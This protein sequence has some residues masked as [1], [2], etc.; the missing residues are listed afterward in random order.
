MKVGKPFLG[1]L[2]SFNPGY[3][4]F[5]RS[6]LLKPEGSKVKLYTGGNA[7]F[8]TMNYAVVDLPVCRTPNSVPML[9]CV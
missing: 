1:F 7:H 5:L 6:L 3:T 9:A 2:I 8:Q 4:Q